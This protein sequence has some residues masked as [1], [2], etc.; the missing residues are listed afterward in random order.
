MMKGQVGSY[1]LDGRQT[2][3]ELSNCVDNLTDKTDELYSLCLIL[4]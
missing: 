4:Y 3:T 1:P 2:C